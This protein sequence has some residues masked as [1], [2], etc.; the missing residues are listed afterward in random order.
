MSGTAPGC[1]RITAG[2]HN[3]E[4]RLLQH[5]ALEAQHGKVLSNRS[6]VVAGAHVQYAHVL[7][8]HLAGEFRAVI[9]FLRL[10]VGAETDASAEER[11]DALVVERALIAPFIAPGRAGK[12]EK[13]GAVEEE[14]ALFGK[15]QGIARQ[16]DLALVDLGLCEVG[17]DGEVRT[18]L[19]RE[20]IEEIDARARITNCRPTSPSG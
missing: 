10:A 3:A 7:S 11:E 6:L 17:V 19:R 13:D 5:P 1:K 4:V 18:E 14:V 12:V 9:D 15:K 20:V 16:V 2:V 8:A